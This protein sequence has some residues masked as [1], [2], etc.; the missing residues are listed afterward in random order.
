MSLLLE[1]KKIEDRQT[2]QSLSPYVCLL[3]SGFPEYQI[4]DQVKKHIAGLE[5]IAV[6][7]PDDQE[8]QEVLENLSEVKKYV[9]DICT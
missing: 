3:K 7:K 4:C 8:I 9:H 2:R 5:S 1:I 6:S